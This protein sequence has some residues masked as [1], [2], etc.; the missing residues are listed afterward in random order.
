MYGKNPGLGNFP[1]IALVLN[2]RIMF[3]GLTTLNF[4]GL[5]PQDMNLGLFISLFG[6]QKMDLRDHISGPNV[7]PKI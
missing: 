6:I 2:F 3:F 1:F 4:M 7:V 5:F